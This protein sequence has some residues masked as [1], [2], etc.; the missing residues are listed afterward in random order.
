MSETGG[1]GKVFIR[2]I[3]TSS[4]WTGELRV[5]NGKATCAPKADRGLKT[6]DSMA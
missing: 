4:S 2:I 5:A 6:A 1:G 3:V